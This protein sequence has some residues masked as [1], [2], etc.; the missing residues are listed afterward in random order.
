MPANYQSKMVYELDIHYQN[1]KK[2]DDDIQRLLVVNFY[3]THPLLK[4]A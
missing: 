3:G 1:T 2:P 4:G